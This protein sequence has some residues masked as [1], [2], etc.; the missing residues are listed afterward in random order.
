M[1]LDAVG[2]CSMLLENGECCLKLFDAVGNYWMK[3]LDAVGN[4]S[5]LLKFVG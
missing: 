5:M 2:N 4:C 1:L 3:L